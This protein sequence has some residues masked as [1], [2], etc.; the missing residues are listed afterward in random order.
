MYVW[1]LNLSTTTLVSDKIK[2]ES[3]VDEDGVLRLW[4]YTNDSETFM[5]RLA[6]SMGHSHKIFQPLA[7]FRTNI[8]IFK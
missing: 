8:Y 4:P 1:R 2:K 7:M 6:T 5:I 3:A